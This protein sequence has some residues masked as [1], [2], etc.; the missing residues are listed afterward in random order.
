MTQLASTPRPDQALELD[1]FCSRVG[2]AW[3]VYV[4]PTWLPGYLARCFDR[5]GEAFPVYLDLEDLDYQMSVSGVTFGKYPSAAGGAIQLIATGHAAT[6]LAVWL[7]QCFASDQR[8]FGASGSDRDV[9]A[10]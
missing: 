2:D 5:H 8:S 3:R 1:V 9:L 7:S 10:G 6:V 4:R